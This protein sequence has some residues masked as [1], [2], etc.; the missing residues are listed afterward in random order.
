MA[1]ECPSTTTSSRGS[2]WCGCDSKRVRLGVSRRATSRPW[3]VPSGSPSRGASMTRCARRR[4]KNYG[5]D[6]GDSFAA[7][8]LAGGA[9]LAGGAAVVAD[10]QQGEP[11]GVVS[12]TELSHG[13]A[14][15]ERCR[16][17]VQHRLSR[18]GLDAAVATPRLDEARGA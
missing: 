17:P 6:C 16:A 1:T 2:A 8:E 10:V 3:I 11:E 5:T 13:G 12:V 7:T 18:H 14:A 4:W 9:G 15:G